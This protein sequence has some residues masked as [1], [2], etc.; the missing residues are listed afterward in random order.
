MVR[1]KAKAIHLSNTH[2]EP[3]RP[4]SQAIRLKATVSRARREGTNHLLAKSIMAPN[5]VKT[6]AATEI[7][8]TPRIIK[9]TIINNRPTLR[10]RITHKPKAHMIRT[11]LMRLQARVRGG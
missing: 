2:M 10:T 5:L 8:Q 3:Q 1:V 6:L 7:S 4:A 11:T 9:A